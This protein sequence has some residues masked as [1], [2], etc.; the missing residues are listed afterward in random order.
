[1]NRRRLDEDEGFHT[2][3]DNEEDDVKAVPENTLA[4]DNLAEGF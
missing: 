2:V 3:P 1:M 4:S